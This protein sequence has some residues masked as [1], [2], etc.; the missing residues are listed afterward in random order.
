MCVVRQLS[1]EF[2]DICQYPTV[3]TQSGF[4]P[5]HS[6]ETCHPSTFN[7]LCDLRIFFGCVRHGRSRHPSPT[8]VSNTAKKKFWDRIKVEEWQ[9]QQPHACTGHCHIRDRSHPVCSP[10]CIKFFGRSS[11]SD[12]TN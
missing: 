3:T 11:I 1:H 5:G 7:P 4:R 2:P 10:R 6:T 9:F 8:T 12:G